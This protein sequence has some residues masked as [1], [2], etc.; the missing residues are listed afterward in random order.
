[1]FRKSKIKK[2]KGEFECIEE[3][4]FRSIL[5]VS[6]VGCSTGLFLDLV[7]HTGFDTVNI[8]H[9]LFMLVLGS[10]LYALKRILFRHITATCLL[11]STALVGYRVIYS[12]NFIEV[13]GTI[14]I[15]LGFICSVTQTRSI[16]T[17][18]HIYILLTLTLTLLK[19]ISE[20]ESLTIVRQAIPYF[21]IFF[22]VTISSA[23]LKDGYQ[24]N[25]K[26]LAS[27]IELLNNK[28]QKIN[29]QHAKLLKSYNQL[30]NL[31]EN[32]EQILKEKTDHIKEKNAQLAQVAFTNAHKVRGPLARILGLVSLAE[33]D[34]KMK[35]FYV[36]KISSEALAMDRIVQMLGRTIEDN[37]LVE[38]PTD[39]S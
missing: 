12:S 15:G 7:M 19:D 32:L 6:L 38:P 21:I 11:I 24:Q 30:S 16:R 8:L 3:V 20:N 4:F 1:M 39:N 10:S 26:Q 5:I 14:L 37:M 18:L 29:S 35:D 33:L 36:D 13:T 2:I 25:Q 22:I 31:N 17:I 28:N 23:R 27:L 9:F 34:P